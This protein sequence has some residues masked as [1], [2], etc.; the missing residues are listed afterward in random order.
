MRLGHHKGTKLT[1]P[2]IT[3]VTM[4]KDSML[5]RFLPI[6]LDPVKDFLNFHEQTKLETS[7][8]LDLGK[9]WLW[10]CTSK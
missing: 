1:E 9:I 7:Q 2:E 8:E 10:L 3:R 5:V 4:G 6:T